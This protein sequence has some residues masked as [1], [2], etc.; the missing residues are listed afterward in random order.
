V[1]RHVARELVRSGG[2][3]VGMDVRPGELPGAEALVVD[4]LDAGAVERSLR[5]VAPDAAIH[6]VG[7]LADDDLDALLSANVLA[8]QNLLACCRRMP[9]TPRLIV[10][11]SAAQY[12]IV[13]GGREV[14]DENRPLQPRTPYALTKCIQEQWALAYGRRYDLGVVCVRPFNILGPGQSDRL[15]P[16]AFLSQLRD[17]RAGRASHVAVGNLDARRDFIDVR[18]VASALAGLV[19]AENVESEVFNIASGRAVRIGDLLDACLAEA[20]GGVEVRQDP[21]RL[22]AVDV[23]LI[24]G[25][26]DKLRNATGWRPRIDWRQS[27]RDAWRGLLDAA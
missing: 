9:R 26:C 20:G 6:L 13:S 16:A 7:S 14:V 12:G 11:G 1:G 21:A 3:V 24:V 25:S 5:S 8:C 18:D 27:V 17:I 22:R 4:L 23:P 19:T 2:R 15:V 10:V